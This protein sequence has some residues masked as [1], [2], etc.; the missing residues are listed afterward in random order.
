MAHH[1]FPPSSSTLFGIQTG[2]I[3]CIDYCLHCTTH[4]GMQHSAYQRIITRCYATIAQCKSFR[5]KN[6]YCICHRFTWKYSCDASLSC[7]YISEM[8]FSFIQTNF[9]NILLH[10]AFPIF[11]IHLLY[12]TLAKIFSTHQF[13]PSHQIETHMP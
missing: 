3:Q 1:L 11:F 9:L 2:N 5:S 10:A 4:I 13:K 6:V 8:C 12:S 7:V